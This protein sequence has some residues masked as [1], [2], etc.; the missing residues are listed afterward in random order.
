MAYFFIS[1]TLA[2]VSLFDHE[3]FS[4]A[5]PN[6]AEP[7]PAEPNMVSPS[8]SARP[9]HTFLWLR[10]AFIFELKLNVLIILSC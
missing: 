2:V 4:P 7:N 9:A 3:D 5:E 8:K 1:H 6:P 10:K